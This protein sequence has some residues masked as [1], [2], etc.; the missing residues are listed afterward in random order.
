MSSLVRRSGLHL[1][2]SLI[3]PHKGIM[4]KCL[5]VLTCR[6]LLPL[7]VS[8]AA[9]SSK[10]R[11]LAGCFTWFRLFFD[12]CRYASAKPQGP[13]SSASWPG[14]LRGSA[15]FAA[16][17]AACW[18]CSRFDSTEKKAGAWAFMSSRYASSHLGLRLRSTQVAGFAP[19]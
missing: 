1:R 16:A 15:S 13:A 2:F 12:Y 6:R 5:I 8:K 9:R 10:L 11:K 19:H 18:S 17:S 7:R 14:S 3:P 4:L